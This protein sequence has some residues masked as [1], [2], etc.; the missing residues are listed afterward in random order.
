MLG[1]DPGTVPQA[2][3]NCGCFEWLSNIWVNPCLRDFM[4]SWA[5]ARQ[6]S[7]L[8]RYDQ[9]MLLWETG[10]PLARAQGEVCLFS[11][12]GR[13]R[14]KR[15]EPSSSEAQP[16]G[17][18]LA[19]VLGCPYVPIRGFP[20][21]SEVKES[22]CN[23][24]R[25]FISDW[26]CIPWYCHLKSFHRYGIS[27]HVFRIVSAR[28]YNFQCASLVILVTSM[29]KCFIHVDIIEREFFKIP[30]QIIIC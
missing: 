15:K 18:T 24:G 4:H 7:F 6:P 17:M 19:L 3:V 12:S 25:I 16:C 27:V 2:L 28:V 5:Q 30:F 13:C 29:A 23:V 14:A 20:G 26:R 11:P 8:C 9:P 21:G 1:K 10:R 22:A